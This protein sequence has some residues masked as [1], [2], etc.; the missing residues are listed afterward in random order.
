VIFPDFDTL[1]GAFI[2]AM[3]PAIAKKHPVQSSPQTVLVLQGGG[4]LGAYQGG[5]FETLTKNGFTLDWVVGTSIGAI[6]GAI[7]AGKLLEALGTLPFR[8]IWRRDMAEFDND[9]R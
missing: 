3:S 7:I 8:G 9:W 4:A 6:N 5:V 1:T 2:S